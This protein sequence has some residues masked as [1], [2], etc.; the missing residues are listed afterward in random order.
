MASCN[1]FKLV[2]YTSKI[3]NFFSSCPKGALWDSWTNDWRGHFNRK[4]IARFFHYF[5]FVTWWVTEAATRKWM[6]CSSHKVKHLLSHTLYRMCH[7]YDQGSL[8]RQRKYFPYLFTSTNWTVEISWFQLIQ[9]YSDAQISLNLCLVDRFFRQFNLQIF[10]FLIHYI[11]K[12]MENESTK[13]DVKNKHTTNR[14]DQLKNDSSQT[15]WQCKNIII[16]I[17]CVLGCFQCM[18][19]SLSHIYI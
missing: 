4:F 15:Y 14:F 2:G 9:H 13:H 5:W 17:C 3:L 8:Y 6:H 11:W 12:G 7:L 10:F 1:T 16:S 18:V 19:I